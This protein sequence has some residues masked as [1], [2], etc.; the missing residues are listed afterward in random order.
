MNLTHLAKFLRRFLNSIYLAKFGRVASLW[1][2]CGIFVDFLW[3]LC[4]SCR[5]LKNASKLFNVRLPPPDR[6]LHERD[7]RVET[8]MIHGCN[9]CK[10][11]LNGV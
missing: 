4:D 10:A 6:H 11:W 8:A 1:N 2:F 3:N 5:F 7:P 9:R